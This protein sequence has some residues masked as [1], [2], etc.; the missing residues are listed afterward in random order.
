M[1]T[2]RHDTAKTLTAAA[3][4]CETKMQPTSNEHKSYITHSL[5]PMLY[6][7]IYVM[8]WVFAELKL[9]NQTQPAHICGTFTNM[10][11]NVE[12]MK[13][14]FHSTQIDTS[15]L[16]AETQFNFLNMYIYICAHKWRTTMPTKGCVIYPY[17]L[18]QHTIRI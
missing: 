4:R 5:T 7:R 8:R 17:N 14:Y 18:R 15:R 9:Q 1:R 6:V 13:N 12:M 10:S 3:Q 16:R 2:W 11:I